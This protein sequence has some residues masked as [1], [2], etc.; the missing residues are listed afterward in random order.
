VTVSSRSR[1][2]KCHETRPHP[3][4]LLVGQDGKRQTDKDPLVDSMRPEKKKTA[5]KT[6]L[7]RVQEK[8]VLALEI[9]ELLNQPLHDRQQIVRDI[10]VKIR[11]FTRL[12]A[13]G[14]RLRDREDFPYFVTSGF[15]DHFVEAQNSLCL[16]DIS[17]AAASDSP[18]T[19]LLKCNCGKIVQGQLHAPLASFSEGGTFWT[20][21][22]SLLL[23]NASADAR[24]PGKGKLCSQEGYESVALIPLRSDGEIIGLLQLNDKR[25]G[26][27][28][29]KSIRCFE[30]ISASIGV[31]L[32]RMASR[33]A[34]AKANKELERRAEERTAELVRINDHLRMQIAE[35]ERIEEALQQSELRYR[36]LVETAREIIWTVDLK[37]RYTYVSPSVSQVLGYTPEEVVLLDPLEMLTPASRT[38]LIQVYAE[39]LASE[40]PRLIGDARSRTVEAEHRCKDGSTVWMETTATVLRGPTGVPA[41]ILGV[42]REISNRKQIEEMKTE[43]ITTAAH[44]LQTP[45]TSIIGYSE[46]LLIRD[47]LSED[48]TKECLSRIHAQARNLAALVSRLLSVWKS[49]TGR[50]IPVDPA[51]WPMKESIEEIVDSFRTQSKNHRFEAVFPEQPVV[52]RIQRKALNEVLTSILNNALKYSPEGGLIRLTCELIG[53]RCHFSIQDEG[54]G[55]TPD[56]ASRVFDRFYRADTSNTAVPGLGI[57]MSLVKS[58]IEAEGGQVWIESAYGKGTTVRFSLPVGFADAI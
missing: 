15:P 10:V 20:N 18:G 35:R 37:G 53:D 42:S 40:E 29:S 14:V 5:P 9:L 21:S 36:T 2:E 3:C 27:F 32:E 46:L 13:V 7:E 22:M 16:R 51:P 45:L 52:L 48:E 43:F 19:F 50:V 56:Q 4:A 33:A 39:E 12:D 26:C 49:N 28:T 24:Q 47:D 25:Q 44:E 17:G 6:R 41:G 57:G 1:R 11:Q 30:G 34:L 55:M 8:N 58:L 38:L 31:A 54:I 23:D